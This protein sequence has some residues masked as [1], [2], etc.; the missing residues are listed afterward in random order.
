MTSGRRRIAHASLAALVY[1]LCSLAPSQAQELAWPPLAPVRAGQDSVRTFEERRT[2][3]F[4]N[5][6]IVMTGVLSIDASGRLI[7]DVATPKAERI[8]IDGQ[9]IMVERPPGNVVARL[10]LRSDPVTNTLIQALRAVLAADRR[11]LEATFRMTVNGTSQQW[12]MLL[13]P[14]DA[15]VAE[16]VR[17]LTVVGAGPRLRG[18]E[19]IETNDA[20]TA[21]TLG[22]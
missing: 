9:Q 2:L 18:I 5:E 1:M 13:E 12:S 3:P 14:V 19:L 16:A 17:S 11:A 20:R 4:L 10:A 6:A 21:V 15:A 22:D 8:A 7:K